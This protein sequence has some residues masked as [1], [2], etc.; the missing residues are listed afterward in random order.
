MRFKPLILLMLFSATLQFCAP[1]KKIEPPQMPAPPS[2]LPAPAVTVELPRE[3]KWVLQSAEYE[4]ICRVVYQKAWEAVKVQ[5]KSIEGHW[6]VVLDIDE[7]VLSNASYE[8]TLIRHGQQYPYF[9][10]EWIY[11]ASCPPVP[12]ASAFI[13][14]VRTL[15]ERAHIVYITNRKIRFEE[16]TML[17]LQKTG[18]WRDDDVLLCQ[19]DKAD[20]KEW[21]R[22]QVINGSGRC[23]G[24]GSRTIVALI[25]DQLGDVIDYESLGATTKTE[26]LDKVR[27]LPGWGTRYFMLPNPIYGDWLKGY[28]LD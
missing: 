11:Q 27:Q 14:S 9:W 7:T 15:G 4:A 25:G 28:D 3:L 21:R 22:Q 12:G 19:I 5:A 18:I 1:Y 8:D 16:A 6:A 17:N 24:K 23:E 20:T 13:D 26:L 10:D 2:P